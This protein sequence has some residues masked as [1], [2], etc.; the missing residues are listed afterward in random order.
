[1]I[2][3]MKF[4]VRDI[5]IDGF[6]CDAAKDIPTDFWEQA[7][8]ELDKIRPVMMLSEGT[9]P[10]HHVKAFDIT[11]SWTLY[12]AMSTVIDG[13][14]TAQ[15]FDD[16]M[17][18]EAVQFPKGAL[19]LRFNTNH[20]K[21][22]W[23]APAVVKFSPKGARTTAV[24]S[25]TFPGVPLIYNGEE[26]GNEKK[27]SLFEKVE[28]DWTKNLEFRAF[29]QVLAALRS[30]HVAL[31]RGDYVPVANSSDGKVLSFVR[32]LGDDQVLVVLNFSRG[33]QKCEIA[34][35]M[36][37]SSQFIEY[38]TKTPIPSSNGNLSLDMKGL[39]YKVFLT[40]TNAGRGIQ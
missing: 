27:L 16:I 35:P 1:M 2:E 37:K 15:I 14:M 3:M 9:L 34:I 8:S 32:Q 6:R 25:F 33:P 11:Y 19:R 20:D 13:N 28:I 18:S 7:R 4:W 40:T 21:N 31:R 5:G 17:K 38:F 24:L 29:Y 39:D 23:D 10:E 22:V 26:A 30:S 36:F 12:D